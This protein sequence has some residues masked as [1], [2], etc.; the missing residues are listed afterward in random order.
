MS[1]QI[2][3]YAVGDRVRIGVRT[4]RADT[5]GDD[6]GALHPIDVGSLG[7]LL[8]SP[9][10]EFRATIEAAVDAGSVAESAIGA[11]DGR[12][13][14][15]LL[16]PVDGLTEVWA[17]GVTYRRSSEAR[18]EE[19][20]VADVYARVYDAA[21]PELFFKAVAWRVSG[22]GEPIGVRSDSPV[23]VPEPELALVCNAEGVVV[24]VTICDDVSSRSIEGENP[25][26]LPQAK[27]YA[28][29]CAL[30]PAITPIWEIADPA[31]L[32]IGMTVWRGDRPT[33]RGETS[34]AA[35]QRGLADLVAHLYRQLSFPHG[36]ILST[37]TGLVPD[38]SFTLLPG[39][40]VTIDIAGVGR[41]SNP[42]RSADAPAFDWLTPAP[43][44]RP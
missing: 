32:A 42:V 15:R 43:A 25:L 26:Y 44:R 5:H 36:A 6:L 16:P 17:S 2:V 22:H 9:L 24:G 38:L 23:N 41:L 28:G 30:G 40:E 21:R 4:A 11:T 27:V 33:W 37:G 10:A 19:S 14:A 20:E 34:T 3:R 18:Q 8:A 39:D 7:E 13:A 1:T 35:M 31:A 12:P 29:A